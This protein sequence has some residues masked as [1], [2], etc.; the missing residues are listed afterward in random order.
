MINQRTLKNVIRATGV[1]LHTGEKI[2][3][4]LRP[5]PVDTGVVFLR[6]D[7]D[8]VVKIPAKNAFV[9]ATTLATTLINDGYNVSTIEHLMSAFSGLGIDNVYV[10]VSGP[11]LPIMDGSAANFVFLIQ[12]A[13]VTEQNA[14]KKFI[15]I[16]KTVKIEVNDGSRAFG[17]TAEI[18]PFDG[19]RL[20][21]TIVY[22]NAVIKEQHASVDFS[23]TTFVKEISR[24]RTFGL[25]Q[26][27]EYLREKNLAQGGSMDNT[28]IVGDA[29][30]LNDDGLRHTD[31]FVRH[32]ILD[33]IGDLYLIGSSLIGEFVGFK[34]GHAENHA[35]IKE[36]MAQ[37][38]AWEFVTFGENEMVPSSY[39]GFA[40]SS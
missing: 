37:P 4:T 11:E 13:G 19:F 3:L 5:A 8:P 24:A 28:I 32:K 1:G 33:A 34:S 38:D 26:D 2:Y 31:E 40:S 6:V 16:K 12:S 23:A 35:L 10:E 7:A 20:S 27:V 18:R 22:D 30:V 36:I 17:Q 14:L 25:M 21:H 29:G 9:G 15:R 39:E